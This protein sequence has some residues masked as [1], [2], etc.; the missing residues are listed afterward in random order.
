MKIYTKE[1]H[2]DLIYGYQAQKIYIEE[3][4][5]NV[6]FW[7]TFAMMMTLVVIIIACLA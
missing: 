5:K 1:E 7:R 4:E 6:M 2:E 3:L